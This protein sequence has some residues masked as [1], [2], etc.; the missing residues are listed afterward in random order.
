MDVHSPEVRSFNMSR[1]R[2]KNTK[3]ERTVRK[4]CHFLGLRYRLYSN[5][6]PGKPDLLFR[7][8][9]TIIFVN[10]CFWHSCKCTYGQKEPKTNIEYWKKKRARTK[11]RDRQNVKK[12]KK[13]GWTVKIIWECECKSSKNLEGRI[14]RIFKI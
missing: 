1:I 8:Y 12:L 9:K 3:P 14:R 4:M 13:L 11:E 2:A 10:G 7:K 6:L 5:K